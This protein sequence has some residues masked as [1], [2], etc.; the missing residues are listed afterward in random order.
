MKKRFFLFFGFLISLTVQSAVVDSLTLC[1][2]A[3]VFIRQNYS[4]PKSFQVQS[5]NRLNPVSRDSRLAVLSLCPEGW[6]LMSTDDVAQ[7]VFGYNLEGSFDSESFKRNTGFQ[8]VATVYEKTISTALEKGTS[9]VQDGWNL[10]S[11]RLRSSQVQTV[12]VQP[13]ISVSWNQGKGW[14]ASCPVDSTGPGNHVY[15]GCVAVAMGQAMTVYKYPV[16]G[17]GIKSYFDTNYGRQTVNFDSYGNY[18]WTKIVDGT[19][20]ANQS[21][22]DF[23]YHCAVTVEMSFGANGSGT[24]TSK[25]ASALPTFFGYSKNASYLD[26]VST[27]A[28]WTTLLTNE[29]TNG[30]PIVYSGDPGTGEP[31]HAFNID[32][33]S[34]NGFYHLN[35]GWSGSNN[36]YFSINVLKPGSYDFTKGQ[37]SVIGI[38]PIKAGPTDISLSSNTIQA[39]LPVGTKVGDLVVADELTTNTYTYTLEGVYNIFDEQEPLFFALE[40]GALVTTKVFSYVTGQTNKQGALIT[41]KDKFG[42][43]FSKNLFVTILP[44]TT[45]LSSL[46]ESSECLAYYNEGLKEIEIG[47]SDLVR[48]IAIYSMTGSMLKRCYDHKSNI[49]VGDLENGVYVAVI[50]TDTSCSRLKFIL[51]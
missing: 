43:V 8:Y 33:V 44:N 19:T 28:E 48:E 16:K 22:A 5:I 34:S 23:L 37:G 3:N 32:G 21:I 36:G 17:Q 30:R 11:A 40:N 27:D 6:M 49:S 50:Q 24:M 51:K 41:A 26:R 18:D 39:G 14:N 15:A 10:T 20:S 12:D 46:K 1:Q 7:P 4:G 13:L 38:R 2:V 35:W 42:N 45:S 9:K 25:I 29:L 31:G 47:R